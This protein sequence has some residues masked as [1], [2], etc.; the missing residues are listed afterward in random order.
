M[1][2]T[3]NRAEYADSAVL[4]DGCQEQPLDLDVSLPDY[5]PDIQRILKCQVTPVFWDT[6]SAATGW[7]STVPC[8]CGCCIWIPGRTPSDAVKWTAVFLRP[9]SAGTGVH[10]CAR[11]SARVEY[12]NCRA[13]S[14]RRLDI[15]GAFSV[16]A[17]VLDRRIQPIC[18]QA[19]EEQLEQRQ[20][21]AAASMLAGL[22]SQQFTV[23]KR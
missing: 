13:A 16:C 1:E 10:P 17:L 9:S 23:S 11:V 14:P 19:Q 21:T 5:C 12:V 4:F 3:F 6:A 7:K 2:Y 20:E 8:G 22:G 18:T 15:H